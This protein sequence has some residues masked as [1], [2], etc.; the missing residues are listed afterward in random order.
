MYDHMYEQVIEIPQYI[1][2]EKIFSHQKNEIR[3]PHDHQKILGYWYEGT[4]KDV[5]KSIE[6]ALEARAGKSGW[7]F[8]ENIAPPY[9]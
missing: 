5:S 4:Q 7:L 3:P 1:G 9:F 8:P 6:V 2:S